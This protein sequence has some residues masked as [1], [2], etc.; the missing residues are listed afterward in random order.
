MNDLH[1]V[2]EPELVFG[3]T[4]E[5]TVSGDAAVGRIMHEQFAKTSFENEALV[6]VGT[7]GDCLRCT[8]T[9]NGVTTPPFHLNAQQWRWKR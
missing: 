1:V 8:A 5:L 3:T 6:V 9:H 7:V 2:E 4:I